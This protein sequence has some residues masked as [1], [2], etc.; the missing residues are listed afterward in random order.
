MVWL[1]SLVAVII[2]SL[3][4]FTGALVLF[5]NKN[6]LKSVLLV[7]VAFSTGALLG[8]AF[9]HLI[10]EA[11]EK[12]GGLNNQISML[13]FAGVLLFFI[14]EKFLRWR[15]CHDIEC[16]IHPK[17]LGMMNLVGDSVHN[18][19]DGVLVAA[20]FMVSVPLGLTTTIAVVAHEVPQELGDFGVL[21]HSGFSKLKAVL[22]NFYTALAAVAGA[23]LT[24]LLGSRLENLAEYIVP[25]TAGGFIYIALS[26]LVPELHKES[27]TKKSFVQLIAI[28]V[29]L[30][31]MYL[32]L[33]VE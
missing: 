18:F 5:L 3:L 22:F 6:A 16:E 25:L 15:H 17:H 14:L 4:S 24:L 20:S 11:V 1:Y 23:I 2:V 31:A 28:L 10:P 9:I 26:G 32:L 13:V 7:L 29:G 12:S 8:D 19:I 33:L 30:A 21:L 27:G